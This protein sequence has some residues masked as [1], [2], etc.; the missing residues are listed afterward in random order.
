[1]ASLARLGGAYNSLFR[2]LFNYRTWES[3]SNLQHA[4]DRLTWEELI[5]R[6]NAFHIV[7]SITVSID[8]LKCSSIVCLV[9][10][11]GKAT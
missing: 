2:K 9:A 7:N 1:M 8:C 3:V 6:Q 4:F 10:C 5:E 11:F